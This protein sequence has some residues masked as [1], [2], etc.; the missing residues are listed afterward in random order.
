MS[1]TPAILS[2]LTAFALAQPA[3]KSGFVPKGFIQDGVPFFEMEFYDQLGWR[4]LYDEGRK[5]RMPDIL[6][7]SPVQTMTLSRIYPERAISW[8]ETGYCSKEYLLQFERLIKELKTSPLATADFDLKRNFSSGPL[9]SKCRWIELA[10]CNSLN[11]NVSQWGHIGKWDNSNTSAAQSL[12]LVMKYSD[13]DDEFVA[14]RIGYADYSI[15]VKGDK[16]PRKLGTQCFVVGHHGAWKTPMVFS[17]Q[18]DLKGNYFGPY[19][20][21]D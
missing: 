1:L 13:V 3:P 10:T 19:L 14:K 15:R 6:V 17:V 5:R 12:F 11:P 16:R 2:L 18:F 7:F 20:I 21:K 8:S 9:F 4:F